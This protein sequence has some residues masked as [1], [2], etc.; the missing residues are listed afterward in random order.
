MPV[1][2]RF[3]K[4]P[5]I[6]RGRMLRGTFELPVEVGNVVESTFIANLG[7]GP[8]PFKQQFAGIIDTQRV[9]ILGARFTRLGEKK[10]AEGTLIHSCYPGYLLQCQLTI[11]LPFD[12][13]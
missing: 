8:L 13:G 4:L 12:K 10:P 6:I 5:E 9:D 2:G 3:V 7:D 1:Q 11:V